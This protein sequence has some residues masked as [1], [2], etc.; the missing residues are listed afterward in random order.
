MTNSSEAGLNTNV[1]FMVSNMINAENNNKTLFQTKT[2]HNF[3]NKMKKIE[4][5]SDNNN[6]QD[7]LAKLIDKLKED[8]T[9]TVEVK[10][11]E[12][13]IIENIF[14]M[15][16]CQKEWIAKYI[17]VLHLDSTHCTNK[18]KYALFCFVA[19]NSKLK[20]LPVTF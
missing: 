1:S 12:Q 14:I 7:E 6:Q 13:G 20:G 19:Q 16:A 2:L 18:D 8:Q 10:T 4:K 11:N 17:E 5:I 3:L 15:L 9:N